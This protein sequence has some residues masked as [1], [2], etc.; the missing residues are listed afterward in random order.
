M[1]LEVNSAY[2][3]LIFSFGLKNSAIHSETALNLACGTPLWA[4]KTVIHVWKEG[5]RLEVLNEFLIPHLDLV[6][7]SS[8]M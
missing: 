1:G 2:D 8:F 4:W 6:V 5:G 3:K 7:G